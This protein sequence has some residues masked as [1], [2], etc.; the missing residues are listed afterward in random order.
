MA[1]TA[2]RGT[3]TDSALGIVAADYLTTLV[4]ATDGADAMRKIR[5]TAL[6]VNN[7]RSDDTVVGAAHALAGPGSSF[8]RD[9]HDVYL[10]I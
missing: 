1:S 7:V 8:F 10:L 5:F 4:G 3:R 9:S 6:A 2:M